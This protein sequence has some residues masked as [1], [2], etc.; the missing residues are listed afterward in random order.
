MKILVIGGSYFYGRVFVMLTAQQQ[1]ITVVNRGTYSLADMGVAQIKGDR[2][3]PSLWQRI[4]GKYDVIVDFCAYEPGDIRCVLDNLQAKPSQ[5]IQ[6]STVDVYRRGIGG[7]KAEDTPFE[8]RALQGEAGAYIAG[9]VA[10]ER[11]LRQ[12]CGETG[13]DWTVLRPGILY[14]PYNYAPRESAYIQMMV[15]Q[16]ILPRITDADGQFQLVYVKDAAE[17]VRQ[18]L[19]NPLT[20]G[21]SYNI[22]VKEP[23]TYSG[24]AEVLL[25]VC[26]SPVRELSM[27][28]DQAQRQGIPLPFAVREQ[29]TEQYDNEKSLRELGL[30]YTS[31]EEGMARTFRAFKNVYQS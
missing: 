13:V 20:Y 10:L 24:L 25:R 9:K 2:R 28:V 21:Q 4:S 17:A 18:C 11:E 3:E 26:D 22:C 6:I 5:Y 1:E 7:Y 19:C 27:S 23:V 29:E 15:Q 8:D 14:G 16:Q 31:L 12:V 30:A